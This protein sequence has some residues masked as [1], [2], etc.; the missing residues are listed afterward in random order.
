MV[1]RVLLSEQDVY[2]DREYVQM[3]F[4]FPAQGQV[5]QARGI[6]LGG[7]EKCVRSGFGVASVDVCGVGIGVG[8]FWNLN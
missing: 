4:H 8:S 2:F 7:D 6:L 3:C 1:K 5:V